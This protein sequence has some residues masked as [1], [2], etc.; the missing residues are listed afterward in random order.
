LWLQPRYQL[1]PHIDAEKCLKLLTAFEQ[2]RKFYSAIRFNKDPQIQ[3]SKKKATAVF[4]LNKTRNH[5]YFKG[6]C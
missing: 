6:N 3:F 5:M 2:W 1:A 4:D